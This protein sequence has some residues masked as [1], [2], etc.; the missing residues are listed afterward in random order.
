MNKIF[1]KDYDNSF[2]VYAI[3]NILNNRIYIGS[4]TVCFQTRYEK[5][6]NSFKNKTNSRFM[7]N[8]Y[9]K[10]GSHKFAM[11]ILEIVN[12]VEKV[13]GREQYWLDY[14]YDNQ[15]DCYNISPTAG[16]CRG[17]KLTENRKK[18]LSIKA[19]E[20]YKD[21]EF[22]LDFRKREDKKKK[23]YSFVSPEGKVFSGRGIEKFCVEHNLHVQHMCELVKGILK[24]YNGWRLK[25]N[26]D[27]VF[28]RV[29]LCNNNSSLMAK[30]LNVKLVS[31]LNE[32]Y[33]PINNISQF[34]RQHK[35]HRISIRKL[36]AGEIKQTKGWRLFIQNN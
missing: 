1:T 18:N 6:I 4:T 5:H 25:M 32:I 3:K 27:Y 22:Y 2:G 21:K 30:T 36:I 23:E 9:E 35:L 29:E 34:C 11:F 15:K 31:P 16:N 33:G 7:Q 20:R 24:S 12:T 19:K 28:N 8:D 13:L 10:C 26:E 17:I 14:F